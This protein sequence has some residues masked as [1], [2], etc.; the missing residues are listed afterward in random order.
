M[1]DGA[2]TAG[3]W[4]GCW[5]NDRLLPVEKRGWPVWETGWSG[6]PVESG[7]HVSAQTLWY[8]WR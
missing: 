6:A 1:W 8:F 3:S 5:Q 2:K 7:S 4:L